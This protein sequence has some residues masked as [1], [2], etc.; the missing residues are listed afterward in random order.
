MIIIS[1]YPT[2]FIKHKQASDPN[3]IYRCFKCHCNLVRLKIVLCEKVFRFLEQLKNTA[4]SIIPPNSAR[5]IVIVKE[6]IH[7]TSQHV[8]TN[9]CASSC[10]VCVV[11]IDYA[12]SL[13]DIKRF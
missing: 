13:R 8:Q 3:P 12:R 1:E 11:V 10:A 7:D 5:V 6:P 4:V 9:D 2:R